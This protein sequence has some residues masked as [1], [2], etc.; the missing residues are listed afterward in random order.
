MRAASGYRIL[1]K[2]LLLQATVI[3]LPAWGQAVVKPDTTGPAEIIVT[4]TKRAE[5]VQQVPLSISAINSAGLE[6]QSI[7]DFSRLQLLVPGLTFGQSGDDARPAIRGT[8]TQQVIGNADPVVAFYQDGVYRSRPGQQLAIFY[9]VDRVEVARGPQGTL[10]GRNSFGGA[11]NVISKAPVL[12]TAD[13]GGAV[14]ATNYAGIKAEGFVNVPLGDTLALRVSGYDSHR[15]GW[16]INTSNLGNNLHDDDNQLIRGQLKFAPGGGV[17]T[18]VLRVEHWYGGGAG[19]GD[20]GYYAPGVPYDPA[21]GKTNG[22]AGVVDP[23]I[24]TVGYRDGGYAGLPTGTLGDSS[25]RSISRNLPF[26]RRIHQTAIS[27]EANVT[28]PFATLRGI[29]GYTDYDEFRLGDPDYSSVSQDAAYNRVKAQTGSEELQLISQG[30]ARLKWVLGAYFMQDKSTDLYVFG[31]DQTGLS[32]NA[33]PLGIPGI[34]STN[35]DQNRPYNLYVQGP[36]T[37][38]THSIAFYGDAT[39]EIVNGLKLIGGLRWTQDRRTATID[40]V[41]WGG[42]TD[43]GGTNGTEGPEEKTFHKVTWR[44]GAQYQ[45]APRSML[46]G[47]YATGFVAG[48]FSGAPS[49]STTLPSLSTYDPTTDTAIEIGSKNSFLGGKLRVNVAAYRNVYTN[50]V[51]QKLVQVGNAISTTTTNAGTIRSWGIEGEVDYYPTRQA[52]LGLRLNA[53]HARF[54]NYV[55]SN[56]FEEGANIPGVNAF[57]L[58]GLQVPLNPD[59]TGSVIGSYDIEARGIGLLT[60]SA[61]LYYSTSYRTAD[62]PYFFANQSAYATLD[63]SLRWRPERGS[64]LSVEAFVTNLTDKQVLLR[65]T[66]N[67]GSVIYQDFSNPRMFGARLSFNY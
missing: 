2:A 13:F 65:T 60:P 16:V 17:F 20:F 19:P 11:I 64:K 6:N 27:D 30:T 57:Q 61:T 50:L 33:S 10:F 1:R 44:A 36:F 55:S 40:N 32:D 7:S 24:S 15:D 34:I 29:F 9:D 67:S 5:S 23:V 4:A 52:Y 39:Y 21:T 63:M 43:Y 37:E 42:S 3:A 56:N 22:V 58:D 26:E 48:G 28:L 46:Y 38:V 53:A 25:I 49:F 54:G 18:N 66:P 41:P 31:D 47:T 59:F 62:Q 51:T 45:V 14:E 8:R 35:P 12:G